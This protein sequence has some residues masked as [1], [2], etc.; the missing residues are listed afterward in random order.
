[1]KMFVLPPKYLFRKWNYLED[2]ER[3]NIIQARWYEIKAVI[4]IARTE[5]EKVSSV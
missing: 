5:N 3:N 1:M 4:R 2:C